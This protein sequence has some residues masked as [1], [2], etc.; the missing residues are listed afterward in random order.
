M[1][2][3]VKARKEFVAAGVGRSQSLKRSNIVQRAPL[4]RVGLS[5]PVV[6]TENSSRRFKDYLKPVLTYI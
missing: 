3:T 6:T 1:V 5:G 4:L 2:V